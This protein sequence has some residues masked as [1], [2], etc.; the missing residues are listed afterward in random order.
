MSSQPTLAEWNVSAAGS[1]QMP[2]LSD[3]LHRL[4]ENIPYTAM[5]DIVYGRPSARPDHLL[6]GT[7]GDDRLKVLRPIPLEVSVEDSTIVVQ[8]D[9]NRRVW[10]WHDRW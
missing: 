5:A 10:Y 2:P 9:R 7:I 3:E 1:A 6:L 4:L 8:L